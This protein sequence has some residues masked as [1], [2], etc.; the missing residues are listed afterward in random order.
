MYF[1]IKGGAKFQ[2]NEDE[3]GFDSQQQT[4]VWRIG[5]EKRSV[6]EEEEE[7]GKGERL[8][9]DEEDISDKDKS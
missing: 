2:S 5:E 7:F 3:F 9:E 4:K 8:L 1:H 6:C